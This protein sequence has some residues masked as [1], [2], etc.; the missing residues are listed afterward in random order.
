MEKTMSFV[1]AAVQKYDMIKK[2]DR[3][4]VGVSGGKDSLFLLVALH[5]LK[6]YYKEDF[7]IVAVTIDPC[8]ENKQTDFSE[9]EELCRRLKIP[10]H[11]KRT[12]LGKIIFDDRK[13]KNPCSLCARMRRGMLH[14]LC[15]EYDCNK[16]ALGHHGDD[17]IETFFMNMFYGGNIACFSPVTY[18]SRKDITMIRPLIFCEDKQVRKIVR[19][20]NL[21]VVKSACP[22]DGGTKRAEMTDFID[23]LQKK[24]PDIKAKISGAIE[25]GEI[26]GWHT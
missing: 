15:N 8:F 23:D 17:A 25:R 18:L 13:E 10:Y 22:V 1:R 4:A 2:G 24:F 14:D 19:K 16:I 20:L 26:S 7:S 21:P 11:I 12:E 6:R 5:S 9:I 3:I